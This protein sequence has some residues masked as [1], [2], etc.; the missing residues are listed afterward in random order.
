LFGSSFDFKY[1]KKTMWQHISTHQRGESEFLNAA[2]KRILAD[3]ELRSRA[4]AIISGAAISEPLISDCLQTPQDPRYHAEGPFLNSHILQMLMVLY[5]IEE[6]KLHLIDI[7]EFR[8]M[9][10]YEGEFQELEEILKEKI[11]FFEVF[12]LCHDAPKRISV[13]F[14]SHKNSIGDQAGFNT[15]LTYDLASDM[16]NRENMIEAY[17]ELF[18]EFS[19]HHPGETPEQIQSQFYATHEIQ[20]HYPHHDRLIHT[21]VYRALLE[22]F[23]FAHKLSARDANILEEFISNHLDFI[24]DFFEVRPKKMRRYLKMSEKNNVD[25]D[26]FIDL[27]QGVIFLDMTVGSAQEND[28]GLWYDA[29]IL[30]NCFKAEHE[31]TPG[32]RDKKLQLMEHD[33]ATK[34]NQLFKEVGLDGIGL[35]DL[36]EIE[37]GPKLGKVLRQ[38]QDAVI[39]KKDMV[40]FGKEFD[41]EIDK[42][43]SLFYQKSFVKGE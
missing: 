34:R 28:N 9:K 25:S 27:M 20:I 5:A 39:G 37:A 38:V 11:S 21:P 29:S 18:H 13:V 12:A 1:N 24:Q 15:K 33:R 22:R 17:H 8:A 23:V 40:S 14:D 42:R 43:V 3:D 7:E 19:E 41:K 6:E 30:F 26:D 35:M 16:T 10:G 2:M 4:E 32:K 31:Y 36:L